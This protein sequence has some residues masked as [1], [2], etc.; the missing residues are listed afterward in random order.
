M[1]MPDIYFLNFDE[2]NNFIEMKRD[3]ANIEKDISN[4]MAEER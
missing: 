4:I 2:N 1:T 3:N